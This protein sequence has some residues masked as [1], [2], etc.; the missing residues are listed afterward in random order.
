M[1]VTL[2]CAALVLALAASPT[3]ALVG[4]PLT[5][6]AVTILGNTVAITVANPT[7][8]TRDGALCVRLVTTAGPMTVNVPVTAAA[9]GDVTIR[10]T[11]PATV[12]DVLPLGVVV[13]D[14][15]PF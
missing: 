13:D 4:R 3:F 7:V 8:H 9:G 12:L 11:A 5:V 1:H 6:R 15:V 2:A 14:G 10:V